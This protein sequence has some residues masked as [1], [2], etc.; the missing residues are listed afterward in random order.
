[1]AYVIASS[2]EATADRRDSGSGE[3]RDWI[4]RIESLKTDGNIGASDEAALIRHVGDQR[5]SLQQALASVVPE[6]QRR[7]ADDGKDSADRWLA[8]TARSMG[9]AHGRESRRVVDGLDASQ[10]P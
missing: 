9:E 5:E 6:Y 7:L 3:D 2:V 1:M 4:G 10:T 8:E